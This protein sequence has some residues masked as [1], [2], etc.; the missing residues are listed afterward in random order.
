MSVSGT[1]ADLQSLSQIR[2]EKVTQAQF[3]GQELKYL[4]LSYIL[5][6]YAWEAQDPEEDR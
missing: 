4:L 2:M 5:R 6:Y 3:P 1:T